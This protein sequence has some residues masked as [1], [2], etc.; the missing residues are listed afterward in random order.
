MIEEPLPLPRVVQQ[1]WEVLPY[2][3]LAVDD[4]PLPAIRTLRGVNISEVGVQ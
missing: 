4:L 1:E 3:R 2:P